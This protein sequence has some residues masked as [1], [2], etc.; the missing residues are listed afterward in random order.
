VGAEVV[1]QALKGNIRA[2]RYWLST[3]G[4][5]EW[6]ERR[7]LAG[8]PAQPIAIRDVTQMSDAE[9]DGELAE[10]EQ[11]EAQAA[12]ARKRIARLPVN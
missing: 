8:D 5:P 12:M 3:H 2:A 7:V 9:I 10:L 11:C 4:G 1:R 6:Q